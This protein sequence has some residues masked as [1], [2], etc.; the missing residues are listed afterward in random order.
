[1]S[2]NAIVLPLFTNA[3]EKGHGTVTMV[4]TAVPAAVLRAASGDAFGNTGNT[5]NIGNIDNT[6]AAAT[7]VDIYATP[8]Q[9]P[10]DEKNQVTWMS[11]LKVTDGSSLLLSQAAPSSFV[12]PQSNHYPYAT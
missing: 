9:G 8:M 3:H 2:D 1:M 4:P 7:T 10:K 12:Q 11:P 5:G 6:G